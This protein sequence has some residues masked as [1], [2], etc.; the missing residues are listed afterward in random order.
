MHTTE[1][2]FGPLVIS[3]LLFGFSLTIILDQLLFHQFLFLHPT[4]KGQVSYI[5]LLNLIM[6]S[7]GLLSF[8]KVHSNPYSP[9]SGKVF[10]GSLVLGCGI[11]IV[12][13]GIINHAL[14]PSLVPMQDFSFIA[15]G[16]LL[17]FISKQ[18]ISRGK[19]K[20]FATEVKKAR[21]RSFMFHPAGS[22]K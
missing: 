21:W 10:S 16:V 18:M 12:L 1:V 2:K 3:G 6:I 15:L 7:G 22:Q 8:W 13:E 5:L 19:R 14:W 11:F 4:Y 20:F 9:R 17:L